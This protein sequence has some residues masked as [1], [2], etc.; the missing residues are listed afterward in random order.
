[1]VKECVVCMDPI[2]NDSDCKMMSCFH[3]YHAECIYQWLTHNPT[4]PMCNKTFERR[5][6]IK[7]DLK[8]HQMNSISVDNECFF[9]D[10]I[11]TRTADCL[12]YEEYRQAI[13]CAMPHEYKQVVKGNKKK[14]PKADRSDDESSEEDYDVIDENHY[15]RK[16]SKSLGDFESNNVMYYN[17]KN[18]W[19]RGIWECS[20]YESDKG[21]VGPLKIIKLPPRSPAK[22][23]IFSAF[24]S[25]RGSIKNSP[26][27]PIPQADGS[28]VF[29]TNGIDL[30]SNLKSLKSEMNVFEHRASTPH[31]YPVYVDAKIVFNLNNVNLLADQQKENVQNGQH[32]KKRKITIGEKDIE[33]MLRGND[34]SRSKKKLKLPYMKNFKIDD[35]LS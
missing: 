24:Q 3:I 8:K 15:L 10:H 1:M 23:R 12:T 7:L 30:E 21:L 6:D 32:K 26:R 18:Q 14:K 4:C 5:E 20:N 29:N 33:K 2:V 28:V 17:I 13:L 9:S 25:I 22:S 34:T 19:G 11:I 35:F 16:R 31:P 27:H